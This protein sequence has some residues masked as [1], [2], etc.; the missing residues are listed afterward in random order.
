MNRVPSVAFCVAMAA[1]I[2]F[3]G[4]SRLRAQEQTPS[5]T[6]AAQTPSPTPSAQEPAEEERNRLLRS[7]LPR[8]HRA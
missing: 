7:L 5:P 2:L 6:P 1:I 3:P 4:V 8:C